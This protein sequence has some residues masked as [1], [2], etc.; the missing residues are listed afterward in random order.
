[1]I[2]IAV[3][4]TGKIIPEAIGAMQASKKFNVAN[5]WARPHSRDKAAA[6]AEKFKVE[7]FTTDLDDLLNDNAPGGGIPQP[8]PNGTVKYDMS[9]DEFAVS[10]TRLIEAGACLVG[11]CCGTTPAHI[12]EIAKLLDKGDYGSFVQ[13]KK[14]QDNKEEDE[15]GSRFWDNLSSGKKVFAVELDP[16]SDADVTKFMAGARELKDAGIDILTIADCPIGRARMD[17]SL[18]ACKVRRELDLE[19]IP[20]MTCRDRNINATK[21]LMMGLYAEKI[22]NIL[23]VTGD[24]TKDGEA[25]NLDYVYNSLLQLKNQGIKVYVIPGNHDIGNS[26]ARK[27]IDGEA[28]IADTWSAVKFRNYFFYCSIL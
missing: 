9:A 2:N 1:M 18:L 16:P 25:G 22:R 3:L 15:V 8:G 17:S 10:M 12:Y 27:Y 19:A 5:I 24:L 23:L 6:L 7:N 11:G 14:A 28:K 21:A 13:V 4:G 20:H 26:N